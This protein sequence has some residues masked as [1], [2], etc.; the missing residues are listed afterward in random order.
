MPHK[1]VTRFAPSPTGNMHVGGLRTALYNYLYARKH[2]GTFIMRIDDT[3]KER[4]RVEYLKNIADSLKWCGLEWD[5]L[6][7]QSDRDSVYEEYLN[8]LLKNDS[9]Y[10]KDGAVWCRMQNVNSVSWMDRSGVMSLPADSFK[11][12]VIR[13]KD[14]SYT[15]NFCSFVDDVNLQVSHVIRGEDHIVN[16]GKQ[17]HLA[18]LLLLPIPTYFHL[19]LLHGE[20]GDKLSKRDMSSGVEELRTEGIMP[21]A[22]V[23]YIV[24][25]GWSSGDREIYSLDDLKSSFCLEKLNKSAMCINKSKLIWFN[26]YYLK[27]ATSER[28]LSLTNLNFLADHKFLEEVLGKVK[29][30]ASTLRDIEDEL[31]FL[32]PCNLGC[33]NISPFSSKSILPYLDKMDWNDADDIKQGL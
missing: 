9:A 26:K 8:Q 17:V 3:D 12:W 24:L 32:D 27:R 5:V 7:H 28:I 22:L 13:R 14:G 18:N 20:T 16:T 25:L 30:R 6:V 23:N 31:E 11:D 19:P 33:K 4:N 21:E 1:I 10:L 15:Y 2:E 29:E